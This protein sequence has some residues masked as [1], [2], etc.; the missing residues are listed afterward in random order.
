MSRR[1]RLSLY[2]LFFALCLGMGILLTF[3]YDA[4]ARRLE[5][6]VAHASP[7]TTLV[8]G[9]IGP[10]LPL[11]V[12]LAKVVYATEGK[13]G[14]PGTKWSVDRIRLTPAWLALLTGKPGVAFSIDLLAGQLSGR[15]A[16]AH[17]GLSL[18]ASFDHMLLDDGKVVEEHIGLGLA[19]TLHGSLE[20]DVGPDGKVGDAHL[21]A[22]VD[23]AKLKGGKV[24]G[25]TLPAADLGT[26][27]LEVVVAKGEATVKK[28]E[29][30]SPDLDLTATATSTLRPVV[31]LSPV[32]GSLR[33]KPSDKFLDRNPAL[34][35]A[36]GLL[37]SMRKP[38]GTIELPLN[39]TLSRPMSM[40]GFG[41]R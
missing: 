4:L 27:D 29:A 6:E 25:F 32:K 17:G 14:S 26:P 8:I 12:R 2:A 7:G 35:G 20:A 5:Q 22:T 16:L 15:A 30:K 33:L 18:K 24:A 19:G 31:S 23:G 37:G 28:L 40:P 9:E 34:K 36:L 1:L 38:D 21:L 10:A 39:G 13:N 11:G 41:P 3:P